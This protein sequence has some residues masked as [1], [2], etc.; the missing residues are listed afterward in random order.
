MQL[1]TDFFLHNLIVIYFFY[2][3]AF[4][5]MGLFVWLER[6]RSSSFR[7]AKAMGTLGAF[8]IVHG[9]HEW[10]VMFQF[11]QDRV[12]VPKWMLL[13]EVQVA[14][15]V[16]SFSLLVIFG[17]RLIYANLTGSDE[18]AL[19]VAV[20][21]A[22]SLAA[23]W[24]L[25]AWWASRAYQL[26]RD[27]IFPVMD[28]LSRY[29]LAVPGAM[30][31]ASGIVLEQKHFLREGLKEN[32]RDLKLVALAMGLYGLVGQLFVSQTVLFPSTVIHSGLFLR[33]FGVPVQLFRAVLAVGTAVF[34]I[35]A[36]RVFEWERQQQ[37]AQANEARLTAQQEALAVQQR[38]R[39]EMEALN[40]RLANAL[41][42]LT[43]LFDFSRHLVESLDRLEMAE[44]AA[45]SV[46][47][48]VPWLLGCQILIQENADSPL[49][50]VGMAGSAVENGRFAPDKVAS[51]V[52]TIHEQGTAY[53]Y[54][55]GRFTQIARINTETLP[56]QPESRCLLGLPL[57][58]K[59]SHDG[60]LL[61]EVD[62]QSRHIQHREIHLL[63][64]LASQLSVAL[65]NATLY[66]KVLSR[67]KLRGELLAQVVSARERERKRIARELHDGTGQLL[68]AIGLGIAAASSNLPKAPKKALQQL[69]LLKEMSNE[70][71]TEL[72]DVMMN[73]R[74][75]LLDDLGLVPA[76]KNLVDEIETKLQKMGQPAHADFQV[77]GEP[78]RLDPNLETIIFRILQEAL[79]NV[80]KHACADNI[81]ITLAYE[82][83]HVHL[84]VMDDGC[85]FEL[86]AVENPQNG[87]HPLGLLGMQERVSL[88]GGHFA[89]HSAPGNG[90]K[91]DV[92]LPVKEKVQADEKYPIGIG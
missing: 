90:T 48:A 88:V 91:I 62:T 70:A 6:G 72:R 65:D 19:W 32:S 27:D 47:T 80:M 79:T 37:L 51:L 85:G 15:L 53:A 2:G 39:E 17:V 42:D 14:H 60:I 10:I 58:L 61:V 16:V 5:C 82:D 64:A 83:A 35:R 74:P 81:T 20:G 11:I 73:L 44:K 26:T 54:Q 49:S 69:A 89:I 18:R 38:A 23:L 66:Q 84:M 36:I 63:E 75:S 59:E 76:M 4:F 46:V 9:L 7:L 56:L 22:V 55:N 40:G 25:A 67:D 92:Y 78:I 24:A 3:L 52:K 77:V 1:I 71:L 87:K 34:F 21:T 29:L 50:V 31:T 30:L 86:Q 12:S 13:G 8:G 57:K 28:V 41:E 68:T 45:E 33:L 43:V